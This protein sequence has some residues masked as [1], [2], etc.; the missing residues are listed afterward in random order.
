MHIYIIGTGP[1]NPDLLTGQAKAAIAASPI[2]VGDKRMLAPFASSGK[3]LVPTYRR[4]E[5]CRLAASLS[6]DEGPMAVLVSGDVGFFSTLF[7]KGL[8]I[9]LCKDTAARRYG[10]YHLRLRCKF[11]KPCGISSHK[12]CHMVKKGPCTSCAGLIHPLVCS[13]VVKICK[14]G[15]FPA[16]LYAYVGLRD[17]PV[18]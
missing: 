1:G 14:F 3:R 13:A 10:I 5:I 15:I 2:L 9:G 17:K 8:N 12:E 4:D 7:H 6:A 18:H 16:K 11:V